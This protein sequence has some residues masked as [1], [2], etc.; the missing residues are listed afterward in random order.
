M[1]RRGVLPFVRRRSP[2]A[3]V[4]SANVEGEIKSNDEAKKKQ[5]TGLKKK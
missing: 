2:F 5:K 1:L 4:R 3:V